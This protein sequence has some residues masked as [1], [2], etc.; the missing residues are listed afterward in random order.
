MAIVLSRMLLCS[1]R[2]EGFSVE[3]YFTIML[4]F[5]GSSRPS[6]S[7][8]SC[9]EC[10]GFMNK[11]P[12]VFSFILTSPRIPSI[13]RML[14]RITTETA[15]SSHDSL[16]GNDSSIFIENFRVYNSRSFHDEYVFH[17]VQCM[18]PLYP[19]FLKLLYSLSS[20]L[21]DFRELDRQVSRGN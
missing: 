13:K 3:Q 20:E 5:T 21:L 12:T 7:F 14:Y 15:L 6:R 9:D 18:F 16:K 19:H 10:T 4:Q 11:L 17:H 2:V 1:F 8:S